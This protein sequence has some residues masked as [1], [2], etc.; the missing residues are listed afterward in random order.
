LERGSAVHFP[1]IHKPDFR[2]SVGQ[3]EIFSVKRKQLANPTKGSQK[4]KGKLSESVPQKNTQKE[5]VGP[6]VDYVEVLV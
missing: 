6:E 5:A 4:D 1:G 3:T 2:Y